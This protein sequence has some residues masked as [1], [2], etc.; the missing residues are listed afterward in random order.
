[1]HLILALLL[2]LF[3]Q[4]GL[5]ETDREF[6][7]RFLFRDVEFARKVSDYS[8]IANTALAF[9]FT[10]IHQRER[11]WE[12]VGG[13]ALAHVSSFALNWGLK[14]LI[15]RER[16]DASD[17]ESMPSGHS[18]AS[19]VNTAAL[20]QQDTPWVCGASAGLSVTT[21]DG[22]VSGEKHTR[23]DTYAGFLQGVLAEIGFMAVWEYRF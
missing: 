21:M 13:L 19:G 4:A 20:C 5:D 6:S 10:A 23:G 11:K 9:T 7:K 8:L 16:P 12:K 1:M 22:R 2:P 3:A 18:A 14:R 15:G 17:H